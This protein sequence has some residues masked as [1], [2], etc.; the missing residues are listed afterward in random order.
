MKL[1]AIVALCM[2]A[3]GCGS[4]LTVDQAQQDAQRE[5]CLALCVIKATGGQISPADAEVM[6]ICDR[7]VGKCSDR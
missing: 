3:I 2:L 7:K 5:R 6:P 1:L 4:G